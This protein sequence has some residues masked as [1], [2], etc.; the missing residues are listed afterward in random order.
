MPGSTSV[1][2]SNASGSFGLEPS[3]DSVTR[4]PQLAAILLSSE[5]SRYPIVNSPFCAPGW[6]TCAAMVSRT[7]SLVASWCANVVT[8]SGSPGTAKG[9][10]SVSRRLSVGDLRCGAPGDD[11][12]N[13]CRDRIVT[14]R[15]RTSTS[16]RWRL[17]WRSLG[18]SSTP[19][20]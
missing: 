18:R 17:P 19:S 9:E 7:L 12:T 10:V 20:R 5:I 11:S 2:P 8:R 15:R 4:L 3:G 13:A 1:E 16:T 14:P 6:P